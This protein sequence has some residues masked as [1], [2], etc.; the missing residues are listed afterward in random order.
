MNVWD[1]GFV[2]RHSL[3]CEEEIRRRCLVNRETAREVAESLDLDRRQVAGAVRLFR[4]VN[5]SLDRLA[6]VV[7][8]DQGLEDCDVAEM[9]CRPVSWAKSVR[10]RMSSIR[11]AEPIPVLLEYLD[12]GLQPEDPSPSEIL[13][14]AEAIRAARPPGAEPVCRLY[15]LYSQVKRKPATA[16]QRRFAWGA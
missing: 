3:A 9:F 10:R 8:L 11:A 4:E 12:D 13:A 6:C 1:G 16:V 5:V 15:E 14:R 2:L 7:M